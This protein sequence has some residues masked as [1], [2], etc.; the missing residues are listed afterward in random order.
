M[1]SITTKISGVILSGGESRRFDGNDKGLIEYRGS[2][3]IE[4]V[5]KR[6]TPQCSELFINC[7]RHIEDYAQFGFVLIQDDYSISNPSDDKIRFQ[8]PL[9]GIATAMRVVNHPL[10]LVCSCDCPQLPM[11]LAKQLYLAMQS[12][13]ADVSYAYDGERNHYLASL[14]RVSACQETL[15]HYLRRGG[16]TVREFYK[17]LCVSTADFSDQQDAFINLNEPDDLRR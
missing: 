8:G 14:W 11:N 9:L 6:I 17:T 2:K 12:N 15:N 7:N 13:S 4:H 5:I 1:D 10:M 16:R 3:L